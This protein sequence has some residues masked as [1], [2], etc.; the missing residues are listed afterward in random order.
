MTVSGTTRQNPV[1]QRSLV[2]CA[3]A[4]WVCLTVGC[5]GAAT[6]TERGSPADDGGVADGGV[7]DGGAPDA[8]QER[9]NP[10][11]RWRG[12]K[13]LGGPGDDEVGTVA[14]TG[15]GMVLAGGYTDGTRGASRYEPGGDARGLLVA[16]DDQGE[17]AWT[18]ALD[19][20]G[21]DVV[22]DVVPTADGAMLVLGRSSAAWPGQAH[23]GAFDVFLA[24]VQRGGT[25]AWLVSMGD[26]DAERMRRMAV[27]DA[28]IVLAGTNDM[29]IPTN[30][31]ERWEDGQAW[32]LALDTV[33]P[34]PAVRRTWTHE[35]ASP[36]TDV[37][38]HVAVSATG[39][40]AV[41]GTVAAAPVMERGPYVQ[42]FNADG[43]RL[44]RTFINRVGFDALAGVAFDAE[45]NLEVA[46]AA[47]G[48]VAGHLP[49]SADG[50][51]HG[52]VAHLRTMDG[53][54]THAFA[55][56]PDAPLFVFDATRSADGTWALAGETFGTLVAGA[57]PQGS[58]DAALVVVASDGTEKLRWQDGSPGDETLAAVALSPFGTVAAGGYAEGALRS[59]GGAPL[60]RRDALVIHLDLP[61]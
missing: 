13:R 45:G 11:T 44:W 48:G 14:F 15:E 35:D 26:E 18:H 33:T 30:H 59:G 16:L 41:V 5:S 38:N 36:G 43:T 50:V 10:G 34:G 24:S 49:P 25:T 27:K 4:A 42:L 52:F 29:Y 3:A 51:Q 12:V 20:A 39:L 54:V 55:V 56:A 21:A 17:V 37:V 61:R 47:L 32:A 22:E 53:V 1:A 31:V 2:W 23:G 58:L 6:G 46:G 40:V 8:G 7:A 19:T 60:G 9:P 28:S 57:D